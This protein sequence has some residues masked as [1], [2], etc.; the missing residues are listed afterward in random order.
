ML[1]LTSPYRSISSI[2]PKN[3]GVHRPTAKTPP[4]VVKFKESPCGAGSQRLAL[5]RPKL[6]WSLGGWKLPHLEGFFPNSN[7]WKGSSAMVKVSG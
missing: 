4:V 6:S 5:A 2:P 1:K 7:S 3:P